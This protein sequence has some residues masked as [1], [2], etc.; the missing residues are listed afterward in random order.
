[1]QRK[2]D[3][4]PVRVP[5]NLLRHVRGPWR[6]LVKP[7][8]VTLWGV[9]LPIPE[10]TPEALRRA[11][12]SERY[13]R[14]EAFC[15][16]RRLEQSDRVLEFGAGIGLLSTLSA[17]RVGSENVASFEA[18]PA[19]IDHIRATHRAN[20]VWPE[21][22]HALVSTS[23]EPARRFFVDDCFMASS[24]TPAESELGI[25]VPC[26]DANEAIHEFRP[27]FVVI[28]VEGGELEL[29]PHIDWTGVSK[30]L[31]EFHP[32]TNG[33]DGIAFLHEVLD[34]RGFAVDRGISSSH[35]RFFARTPWD[36]L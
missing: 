27:S 15:V 7:S 4:D 25:E 29:L 26:V 33:E 13:E 35:K 14:G 18:N 32:Q 28:D 34:A 21:L 17:L 36:E 12:Y 19:L 31:V 24:A 30:L 9:K 23:S 1:M 22:R 20:N 2:N 8:T 10:A 6:Q 3:P 5:T 11:I 16:A